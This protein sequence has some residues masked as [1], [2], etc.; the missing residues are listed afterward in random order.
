M[1]WV[2]VW[3]L[4]KARRKVLAQSSVGID[5]A[6]NVHWDKIDSRQ[7]AEAVV[8]ISLAIHNLAVSYR[9]I[10]I[11]NMIFRA[12]SDSSAKS[13]E[14]RIVIHERNSGTFDN[15]MRIFHSTL[16]MFLYP[17]RDISCVRTIK[18]CKTPEWRT[19][20]RRV[21]PVTRR[22]YVEST[23]VGLFVRQFGD[24][25]ATAT[26]GRERSADRPTDQ[27]EFNSLIYSGL[28]ERVDR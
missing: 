18:I 17:P 8:K 24:L 27:Y 15:I 12:S 3:K 28:A 26:S 21:S 5:F 22:D 14:L 6:W 19:T 10:F 23:V 11:R 25:L 20:M 7:S 4:A 9:F 13:D 2:Y 1:K 16:S